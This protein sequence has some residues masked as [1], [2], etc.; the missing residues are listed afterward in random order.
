[1]GVNEG[2]L[3]TLWDWA[4]TNETLLI[5]LS[6]FSVV[7]FVGS[8]ILIPFLIARLPSD[9]FRLPPQQNR[10]HY[11]SVKA[12]FLN[13]AGILVIFAGI[14]M[15]ILPGQGL[16]TILIGISIMR[17]P[18]K[19]RLERYLATKPQILNALNWIR[20]RAHVADLQAP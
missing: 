6:L 2:T 12:F 10:S 9:Y 5:V 14:A 4:S 13:A 8:L 18:A 3:Q 11:L 7:T 19:Y 20:Q 16:L 15:L 1:M 17:F